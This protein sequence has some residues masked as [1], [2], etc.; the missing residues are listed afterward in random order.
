[1]S[2]VYHVE[3]YRCNNRTAN[4]KGSL[5][6]VLTEAMNRSSQNW[7]EQAS[8]IGKKEESSSSKMK[9]ASFPEQGWKQGKE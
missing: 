4:A 8:I 5:K 3:K 9:V 7:L 6:Q 2:S 1:M